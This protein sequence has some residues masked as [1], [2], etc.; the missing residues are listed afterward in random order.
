MESIDVNMA[1]ARDAMPFNRLVKLA[2]R[3][4]RRKA[5]GLK[6]NANSPL[7]FYSESFSERIMYP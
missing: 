6:W 7:A 3:S 1:K 4:V 5:W 2:S